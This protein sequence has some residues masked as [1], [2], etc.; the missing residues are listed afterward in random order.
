MVTEQLRRKCPLPRVTP[1]FQV[2][3]EERDQLQAPDT[4]LH[5]TAHAKQSGGTSGA[6]DN[7]GYSSCKR[8]HLSTRVYIKPNT[9]CTVML[10]S[11]LLAVALSSPFYR[12][13]S[14]RERLG[15]QRTL[16]LL[17]GARTCQAV[18]GGL[19]GSGNLPGVEGHTGGPED[20]AMH[21][22]HLSPRLFWSHWCF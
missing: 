13:P 16:R 12:P 17:L 4:D 9:P 5:S 3:V 20:T 7:G 19:V 10:A 21:H 22:A 15:V 6:L 11:E 2:R 8:T 1:V 14:T 18:A